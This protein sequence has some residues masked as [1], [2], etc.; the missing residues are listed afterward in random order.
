MF[1]KICIICAAV[2]ISWVTML[3]LMWS[4]F[5]VDKTILATLMGMSVG[6]IATKYAEGLVWKALIV[7]LGLPMVWYTVNDKFA[8]AVI[9][10]AAILLSFLF[11]IRLNSKKGLE[12]ADRFKDCC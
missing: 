8:Y 12:P 1:K 9:L 4:G 3:V 6:A 2:V 7:L 5:A 10:F 11:N